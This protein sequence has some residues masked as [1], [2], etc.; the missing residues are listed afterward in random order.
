MVAVRLRLF[1]LFIYVQ[2]CIYLYLNKLAVVV[3]DAAEKQA[4]EVADV[5][6]I[7]AVLVVGALPVPSV[8]PAGC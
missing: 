6:N 7:E 8:F 4:G 1:F 3:E 2:Y 5:V